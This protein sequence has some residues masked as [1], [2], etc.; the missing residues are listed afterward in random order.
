MRS[1]YIQRNASRRSRCYRDASGIALDA[2]HSKSLVKELLKQGS[3]VI[4]LGPGG[5]GKTTIAAALGIAAA[6]A[7]LDTG[8]ITVDPARRL[9]DALGLERLT[10]KPTRIDSR[11]LAGAGLD[12][13]L[14]LSAMVLDVKGAWNGLVERFVKTAASRERILKNPFYRSLTEQFAGAEAYAALEQL[15]DLHCAARFDVKIVDTPPAAHAFEFI[16][17]PAHLVRLLDSRAAR[18]LF[19]PYAAAGKTVLGL[20]NR[21]AGFVVEQLEQFA[22]IRTLTSISEFFGAAAEAADAIVDRFRKVDAMLHSA[23]VHFVLVTTTEEDRLREALALVR[24]M[25]SE[26]LRLGAIVLN[27][28]LDECTF[29]ALLAAPRQMPSALAEIPTLRKALQLGGAA[30]PKL[31]SIVRYLEDYG[32][33]QRSEIERAACF[34]RELPAIVELAIAPEINVGVRDLGAL[35]KVGAIL[36]GDTNGRSFLTDAEAAFGIAPLA[37]SLAT[38]RKAKSTS[39]RTAR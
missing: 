26:G 7:R 1:W 30:D 23:S 28:M 11:R 16:E 17:A 5:V 21:A 8:M 35:A 4:L 29:D 24:Q 15:Y 18:W 32:A 10:A 38:P 3:T 13:K 27:R 9:R 12:P 25:E 2:A 22:G 19:M 20:A 14:K 36:T 37:R 31:E 6:R 33:N 34:A 39:R